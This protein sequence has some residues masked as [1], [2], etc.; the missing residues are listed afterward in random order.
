MTAVGRRTRVR[1]V[2]AVAFLALV[3][4]ACGSDDGTTDAAS[5]ELAGTVRAEPLQVGD[6]VLPDAATGEPTDVVPAEGELLIAYFGYTS[7]PDVCPTTM[8]DVQRAMDEL[9]PEDAERIEAAFVTVDP[10]R[11]TADVLERYVG[12]FF[13]RYRLLRTEDEAELD[14]AKD[15][16]LASSSITPTGA[17]SYEVSHTG[18]TYV[19]LPDGTVGVEWAFG[20][21]SETM[22][23]DLEILLARQEAPADE[24]T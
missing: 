13:D 10:K 2:S 7:C 1:L 12:Y 18:T 20:T 4:V 17:D 9:D 24:R 22:A 23:S 14:A 21:S 5:A 16:F 6:V 11:D 15:A 8:T 3:V 19:V